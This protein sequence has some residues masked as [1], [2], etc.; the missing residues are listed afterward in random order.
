MQ[1]VSTLESEVSQSLETN[2]DFE[3]YSM[4]GVHIKLPEN[5]HN[6]HRPSLERSPQRER[7]STGESDTTSSLISGDL[8]E[9]PAVR[10]DAVGSGKEEDPDPGPEV[11]AAFLETPDDK[12][13][14]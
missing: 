6:R 10:P 12:G 7:Y 4:H 8:R 2:D 14:S 5:D 11:F 3:M 1:P 9:E 13:P